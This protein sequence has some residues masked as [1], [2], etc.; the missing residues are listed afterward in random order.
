VTLLRVLATLLLAA[1]TFFCAA[2]A[3]VAGVYV[4]HVPEH[5]REG[6]L[7]AAIVF[8]VLTVAGAVSIWAVWRARS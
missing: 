1:A 2:C 3:L 4:P 8:A 5:E 6:V 7:V